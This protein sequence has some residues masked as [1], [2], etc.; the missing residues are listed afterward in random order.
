MKQ[1]EFVEKA[2]EQLDAWNA[3]LKKM[4]AQAGEMQAKG[5]EHFKAQLEQMEE[6]RKVAQDHLDKIH[7]ANVDAWKEMQSSFQDAWKAMEKGMT[8]ARKKYTED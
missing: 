2:K 4:Q 7:K 6:Q 5:Q 3:E 1:D 8:E